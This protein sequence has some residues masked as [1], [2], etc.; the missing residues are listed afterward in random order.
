MIVYNRTKFS[1][2]GKT[3]TVTLDLPIGTRTEI[4]EGNPVEVV[5]Y[6]TMPW[7]T[8]LK[9]VENWLSRFTIEPEVY[10]KAIEEVKLIL[11]VS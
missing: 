5:V 6:R 9:E 4:K 7:F 1:D 11:G 3:P 10:Q 2:G 8:T